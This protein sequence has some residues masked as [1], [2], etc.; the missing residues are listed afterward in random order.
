MFRPDNRMQNTELLEPIWNPEPRSHGGV[1]Y[2][3]SA[4]KREILFSYL[5]SGAEMGEGLVYV[6]SQ[7]T[8]LRVKDGMRDYGIEV[9]LLTARSQLL[10]SHYM[11]VYIVDGRVNIPRTLRLFSDLFQKYRFMG[12]KGM[13]ACGEMG[14]F[15]RQRKA[16]ELIHYETALHRKLFLPSTTG[17]CAYD[18]N[19]LNR[20]GSPEVLISLARAHDP[21]ILATSQSTRILEPENIRLQ[22]I[23]DL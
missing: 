1:F 10:V 2:S 8:P 14:C 3:S 6:C 12:L 11:D 16:S 18:I 7:E 19:E 22:D 17:L 13:R 20:F 15:L 4:R 9:E 21:V 5:K 23:M